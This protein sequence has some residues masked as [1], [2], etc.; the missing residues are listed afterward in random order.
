MHC[1]VISSR[2]YWSRGPACVKRM[3]YY[4]RSYMSIFVLVFVLRSMSK[5]VTLSDHLDF[6]NSSDPDLVTL[7]CRAGEEG[8]DDV[9]PRN[10]EQAKMV[11]EWGR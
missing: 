3:T 10:S 7:K 5:D 9:S 2:R 11:D 8:E 1:Y 4:S 6:E